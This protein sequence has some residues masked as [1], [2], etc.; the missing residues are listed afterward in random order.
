M[1]I[2]QAIQVRHFGPTNHKGS[3][4]KA[5]CAAGHVIVDW[6]HELTDDQNFAR[7]AMELALKLKWNVSLIGGMLKDGDYVF[8]IGDV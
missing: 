8:I 6:D 1:A 4:L 3:R 5:S 2:R 7:A